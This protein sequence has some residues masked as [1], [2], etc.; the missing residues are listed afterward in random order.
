MDARWRCNVAL[1]ICGKGQAELTE[2]R[3]LGEALS[4]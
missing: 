4:E 1:W 3:F 2:E